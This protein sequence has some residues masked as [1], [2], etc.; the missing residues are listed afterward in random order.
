MVSNLKKSICHHLA[1][2][3]LVFA[4]ATDFTTRIANV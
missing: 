1:L 4:E 2:H 3:Q